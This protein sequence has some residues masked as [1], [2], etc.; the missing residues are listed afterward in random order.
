M[1]VV[2]TTILVYAYG[3][4]HPLA[5]PCRA[6]VELLRDGEV[7]ATTTPE[8]LQESTHVRAR[9]RSRADAAAAARDLA[10]LLTPLT[11]ATTAD[12]QRGLE[13]FTSHDELGAFDAVLAAAAL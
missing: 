8:V 4:D 12:L 2:D 6:V 3:I 5:G 13:L 11:V 1:I 9:R 7:S 10:V